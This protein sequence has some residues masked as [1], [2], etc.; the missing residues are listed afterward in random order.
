MT[1]NNE[2]IEFKY[3]YIQNGHVLINGMCLSRTQNFFTK[4]FNSGHIDVFESL[5]TYDHEKECSLQ[6]I[7]CKM[8]CSKFEEKYVFVPLLHSFDIFY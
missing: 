1:K 8:F 5:R 6:E 7:K 2:I 3:T 4:P